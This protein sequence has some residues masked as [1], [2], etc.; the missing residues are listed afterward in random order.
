MAKVSAH[1]ISQEAALNP[2][3]WAK[4]PLVMKYHLRGADF[5]VGEVGI[6]SPSRWILDEPINRLLAHRGMSEASIISSAGV[7]REIVTGLVGVEKKNFYDEE[8]SIQ[9]VR[10][11]IKKE[12]DAL[13]AEWERQ[14]GLRLGIAYA[15]AGITVD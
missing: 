8:K 15:R 2:F 14:E 5:Q 1:D 4:Y 7:G 12:Q 9:E 6:I 3:P 11:V 13:H 10:D